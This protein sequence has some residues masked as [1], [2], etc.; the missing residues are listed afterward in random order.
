MPFTA[1]SSLWLDARGYQRITLLRAQGLSG[2]IE[3]AMAAASN[4]GLVQCWEGP[5]ATPVPT[6]AAAVY[7]SGLQVA[8]LLFQCADGKDAAIMLVAPKLADF[9]A[10]GRTIDIAN[11]QIAAIIAAAVGTLANQAGSIAANYVSGFL[12]GNGG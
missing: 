1:R 5:I 10:D 3:A 8:R 7:E 12:Q 2:A 9:L 11:P 4:A 6:P